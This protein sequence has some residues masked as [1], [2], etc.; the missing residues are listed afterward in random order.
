M[1]IVEI[2]HFKD[3]IE[4]NSR[5]VNLKT[6]KPEIDGFLTFSIDIDKIFRL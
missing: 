5:I 2:I 6:V 3:Q 4:I 1:K